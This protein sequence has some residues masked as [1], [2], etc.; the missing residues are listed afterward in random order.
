MEWQDLKDFCAQ[1]LHLRPADRDL[2]WN[3][4]LHIYRDCIGFMRSSYTSAHAG[5]FGPRSQ[6]MDNERSYDVRA[7]VML[8]AAKI[9]TEQRR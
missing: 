5:S 4:V 2:V 3:G 6:E 8:Q 7:Q 9:K 1:A